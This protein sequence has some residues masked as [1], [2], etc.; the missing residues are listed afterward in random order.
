MTKKNV[1]YIPVAGVS[2]AVVMT[3]LPGTAFA[4]AAPS[5]GDT[6]FIKGNQ[7]TNL[8]EIALGKLALSHSSSAAVKQLATTTMS[9]HQSAKAKLSTVAAE[10]KV[11]LPAAPNPTQQAQAAQLKKLSGT[12]FDQL[13][14]RDQI[15][16][17]H[18]S[19]TGTQTEITTGSSPAV[20]TYAKG[21][22]PVAQMHLKMAQADLAASSGAGPGSV[23]AGSGGAAAPNTGTNLGLDW[24]AG[25]AGLALLGGAALLVDRRRRRALR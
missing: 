20:L 1:R 3:C 8:A 2:L 7:Q 6:T 12:S 21:Y 9:D 22:L 19:I 16:G 4:A 24:T 15:A 11:A 25:A 14:L 5:A 10:L 18:L 13:Y 23:R 17:H